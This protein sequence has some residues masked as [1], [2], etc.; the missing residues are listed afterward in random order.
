MGTRG[1]GYCWNRAIFALSHYTHVVGISDPK[2]R[3][4]FLNLLW[5]NSFMIVSA[6]RPDSDDTMVIPRICMHA[7]LSK[8]K[9]DCT[10]ECTKLMM[11]SADMVLLSDWLEF[12]YIELRL[13]SSTI[14]LEICMNTD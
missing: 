13:I 14:F 7:I 5:S 1:F 6:S 9:Y 3:A 12:Y 2:A 11:S 4:A 8:Y 10:F